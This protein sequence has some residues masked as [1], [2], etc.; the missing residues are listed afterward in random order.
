MNG[1]LACCKVQSIDVDTYT[2]T[3]VNV[4]ISPSYRKLRFMLHAT[5]I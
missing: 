4:S 3:K 5:S 1:R 2:V